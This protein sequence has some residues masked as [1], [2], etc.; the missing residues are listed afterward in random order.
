M[1]RGQGRSG[2]LQRLKPRPIVGRQ[3]HRQL[4]LRR[5]SS[6]CSSTSPRE[7]SQAIRPPS[8]AGKRIWCTCS[9]LLRLSRHALAKRVEPFAGQRR[10]RHDIV[11]PRAL[12]RTA[13]RAPRRPAG[14]PCSTPR[15]AAARPLPPARAM[16]ARRRRP[17]A[18]PRG[19]DAPC[20][21]RGPGDRPTRLPPAS[22]GTRRSA[23]SA[24]RRRIR[25]CPTG[26]TLS[27]PGSRMSRMV[28]SSVANS[29]FSA[30][31]AS[32]VRRLK[33]VDFPALV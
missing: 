12:P 33:S 5:R 13:G 19:R 21:G 27:K 10:D 6:R 7:C 3:P 23:R 8:P 22:P 16:R 30:N 15:S 18:A 31:T 28:G 32:P 2:G 26:S 25:P 9:P 14:R 20:R 11:A 24:G 29:R 4:A 17:R 1:G